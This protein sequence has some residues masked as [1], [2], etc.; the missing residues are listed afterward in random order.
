MVMSQSKSIEKF[1]DR[2]KNWKKSGSGKT[3][4]KDIIWFPK[5]RTELTDMRSM[6]KVAYIT[7]Q[8]NLKS[9]KI[10][11]F[12]EN[13]LAKTLASMGSI[14]RPGVGI[15]NTVAEYEDEVTANQPDVSSFRMLNRIFRFMGFVTRNSDIPNSYI[16]TDLGKQFV[17]FNGPY[18]SKIGS[19]DEND[20]VVKQLVNA[21]M[22]SVHDEP[23]MWDTRFRNRLVVNLL[24]CTKVSGYITNHE[25]VVT[26]FALKD[27]RDN[28][29]I[30]QML[31]RL[32]R[33]RSGVIDMT[34]AYQECSVDPFNK[35]STNN[36]YDSPK[37][38][39]SL[40]R[41]TGLFEN[42]TVSII[43]SSFGDLSNVYDP[44]FSVSSKLS[45]P[46]VV[47]VLSDYGK[48][49]LLEETTK[50][51]IGFEELIR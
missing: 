11:F 49:I 29:Q 31:N 5:P 25:A 2:L 28:N 3:Q 42:Q 14:T 19:L 39:T 1:T 21:N 23:K 38:L 7:Q 51:L 26:A 46:R 16:V 33:L 17:K 4:N 30:K 32:R 45:K 12:K 40:C 22:F 24:R 15:L 41:Q 47:N 43:E 48:Q 37:V 10:N 9:Q 44:M 50:R 18:P 20:F 35:S 36:A 8:E 6:L 34:Q 13:Q 27:E